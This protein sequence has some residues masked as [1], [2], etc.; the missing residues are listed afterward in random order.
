MS[1]TWYDK[2]WREK[3][4]PHFVKWFEDPKEGYGPVE[5][6]TH[7]DDGTPMHPASRTEAENEY[8]TRRGFALMG[9]LEGA[10]QG[11]RGSDGL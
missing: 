7:W 10:D 1:L 6:Y 4:V 9:Y 2:Y 5:M 3:E 8:W 11:K